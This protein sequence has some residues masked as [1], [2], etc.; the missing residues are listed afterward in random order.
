MKSMKKG[1]IILL[2]VTLVFSACNFEQKAA[3]EQREQQNE[4]S[5]EFLEKR[6]E[7]EQMAS[8]EFSAVNEK[9]RELNRII[10]D[11]EKKLSEEQKLLL[12]TIQEK[13]ISVNNRLNNIESVREDEWETFSTNFKEDLEEIQ[14]KLDEV[15]EQF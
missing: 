3:D 10:E 5:E 2:L 8:E 15:L 4:I 9:V 6:K 1:S 13:R 12:D 14:S 7:L 11:Q